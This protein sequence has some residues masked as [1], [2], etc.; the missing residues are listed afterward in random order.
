MRIHIVV[1]AYILVFSHFFS[2]SI[3]KLCILLLTISAVLSA[4][5]VNTVAEEL[6][7]LSSEDYN[8][9]ARIAKDIAAGAVLIT[10][11][12]SVVIGLFLFC[13]K[14]GFLRMACFF[15]VN[16]S[17]VIYLLLSVALS[18]I[19]IILGPKGIK[20]KLWVKKLKSSNKNKE[21]K[22]IV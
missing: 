15:S 20:H 4:E 3:E 16:R 18:I 1:A 8:P 14:D 6:S 11:G 17:M 7:D 5:M 9:M 2:L 13:Q 19:F 12:F 22:R 21:G 10:C